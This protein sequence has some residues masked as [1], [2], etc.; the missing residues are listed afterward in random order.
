MRRKRKKRRFISMGAVRLKTWQLSFHTSKKQSLQRE[1]TRF[2]VPQ[3][4]PV[5]FS[6]KAEEEETAP[7]KDSIVRVFIFSQLL[8]SSF[9]SK[10]CSTDKTCFL[11]RCFS[12]VSTFIHSLDRSSNQ[13]LPSQAMF[14]SLLKQL[15]CY[16]KDGGKRKSAATHG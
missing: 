5:A 1:T 3:I 15:A 7:K 8:R 4:S 11:V 13:H 10:W 2:K 16:T 9:F 14:V 6:E 12:S